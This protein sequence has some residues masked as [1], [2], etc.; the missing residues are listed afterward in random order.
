MLWGAVL[1]GTV[2][3]RAMLWRSH[4]HLTHDQGARP[5]HAPT[6]IAVH[7]AKRTIWISRTRTSSSNRPL[8]TST[9]IVTALTI[10]I[11][12]ALTTIAT[13]LTTTIDTTRVD[14]RVV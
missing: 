7:L 9:S 8:V 11:I 10:T 3:W 6:V 2:L 1:W 4:S 12:T 13:A 5:A 14:I